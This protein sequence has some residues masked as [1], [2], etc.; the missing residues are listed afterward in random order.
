MSMVW[1]GEIK[2]LMRINWQAGNNDDVWVNE[3]SHVFGMR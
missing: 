2:Q 3:L 1:N